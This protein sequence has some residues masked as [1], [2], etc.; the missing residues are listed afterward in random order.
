MSQLYCCVADEL[1]DCFGAW[2]GDELQR[3]EQGE[4]EQRISFE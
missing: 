4:F 3:P 1:F 2:Q